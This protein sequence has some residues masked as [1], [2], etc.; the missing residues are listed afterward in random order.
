MEFGF[1]IILRILFMACMVFIIGYIFGGFSK[2][3]GLTV[4]TKIA[5]ILAIVVFI[6]TNVLLMHLNWRHHSCWNRETTSVVPHS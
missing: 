3:K 5:V 2:S 4:I 1:I 6:G